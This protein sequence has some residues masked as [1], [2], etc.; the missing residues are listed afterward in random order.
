M[1]DDPEPVREF[2][3]RFGMNYPVAMADEKI[4]ELYGGVVGLP[5]TL[6]IGRDGL[7]CER[8]P[9]VIV[10][11]EHFTQEIQAL[12]AVKSR[13]SGIRSKTKSIGLASGP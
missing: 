7:I 5:T 8:V 9:G 3:K 1:D 2:Y 12:L 4:G 10:D 11:F 13:S 6:L